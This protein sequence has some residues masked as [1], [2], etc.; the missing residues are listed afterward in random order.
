MGLKLAFF[1]LVL[2][3]C[4]QFPEYTKLLTPHDFAYTGYLEYSST[5]NW[6]IPIYPLKENLDIN[7]SLKPSLPQVYTLRYTTSTKIEFK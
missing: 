2:L 6:K 3:S 1:V 7:S 5:H 4:Q